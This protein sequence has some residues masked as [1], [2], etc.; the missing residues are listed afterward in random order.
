MGSK[1]LIPE[2][3][4][5]QLY[6][7]WESEQDRLE[8]AVCLHL[9]IVNRRAHTTP[10]VGPNNEDEITLRDKNG[11]GWEAHVWT[12]DGQEWQLRT[13]FKYPGD[14]PPSQQVVFPRDQVM[15][16]PLTEPPDWW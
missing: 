11:D 12:D 7:S 10:Q 2:S 6:R 9:G 13:A 14:K 5:R 1:G 8:H 15:L 4:R 3:L 16:K